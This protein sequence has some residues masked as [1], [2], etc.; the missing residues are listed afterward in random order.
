MTLTLY[1][2]A[3]QVV[4]RLVDE[5]QAAGRYRAYW[6]AETQDGGSVGSGVY[7]YRLQAGDFVRARRLVVV[8]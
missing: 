2:G 3:G 5:V 7:F 1:N 4:S 6:N 8:R